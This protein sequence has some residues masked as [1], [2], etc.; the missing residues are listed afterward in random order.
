M[1]RVSRSCLSYEGIALQKGRI[2]SDRREGFSVGVYL[3]L[4][5]SVFL[6]PVLI[7]TGK[8][9]SRIFSNDTLGQVPRYFSILPAYFQNI[10]DFTEHIQYMEN[11]KS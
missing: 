6:H 3:S 8:Q 1:I 2:L 10:S 11:M 7:P 4:V 5:S 9:V